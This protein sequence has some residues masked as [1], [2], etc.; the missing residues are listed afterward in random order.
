ML[1][2]MRA[3]SRF[4]S[5][6]VFP[7]RPPVRFFNLT[8]Q[9]YNEPKWRCPFP[10]VSVSFCQ[11]LSVSVMSIQNVSTMKATTLGGISFILGRHPM[12]M[13]S[14]RYTSHHLFSV[15]TLTPASR[16]SSD[17]SIDFISCFHL[18]NFLVHNRVSKFAF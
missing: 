8:M 9:S 16:A 18:S 4:K 5:R 2:F 17:F 7:Y 14:S 3:I 15:L 12:A 13:S 1:P 11:F 6:N 10:S